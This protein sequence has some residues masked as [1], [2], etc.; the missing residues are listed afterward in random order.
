MSL[1]C[2]ISKLC[3]LSGVSLMGLAL[4]AP[5]TFCHQ[6][7]LMPAVISELCSASPEVT[8]ILVRRQN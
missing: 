8:D 4:E 3:T 1:I 5:T 6:Q 7:D 2:K